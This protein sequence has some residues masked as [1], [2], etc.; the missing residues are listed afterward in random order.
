MD[1][2]NNICVNIYTGESSSQAA[3]FQDLKFVVEAALA[4]RSF[5]T[6]LH[7]SIR[8]VCSYAKPNFR[9]SLHQVT[10]AL[11]LLTAKLGQARRIRSL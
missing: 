11:S 7:F 10:T 1:S 4:G 8:Y 9:P 5:P 3:V 6:G 2:V